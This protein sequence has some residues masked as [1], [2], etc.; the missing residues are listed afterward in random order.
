MRA[1]RIK[2]KIEEAAAN[3]YRFEQQTRSEVDESA[4]AV[5]R[6]IEKLEPR[7]AK[8]VRCQRGRFGARDFPGTPPTLLTAATRPYA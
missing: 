6:R 1:T 7:T 3:R 2:R 8:L 5:L 4:S